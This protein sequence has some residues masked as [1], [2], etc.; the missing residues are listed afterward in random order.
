MDFLILKSKDVLS[1]L[2]KIRHFLLFWVTYSDL[3]FFPFVNLV[4][5]LSNAYWRKIVVLKQDIGD[6]VYEPYLLCIVE[7]NGYCSVMRFIVSELLHERILLKPS[8]T[9]LLF[10]GSKTR[11]LL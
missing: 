8:S 10:A 2:N 1:F 9:S 5:D 4:F 7:K 3:A 11:H 6:N